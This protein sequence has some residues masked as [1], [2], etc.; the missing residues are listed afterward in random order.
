MPQEYTEKAYMDFIEEYG[1]HFVD[2]MVMGSMFGQQSKFSSS[3]WTTMES[4]GLDISLA[5]RY[6]GFGATA[7][8]SFQTDDEKQKAQQFEQQSSGQSLYSIGA[9][10]PSDNSATTWMAQVVENPV[11]IS[12]QLIQID[13]LLDDIRYGKVISAKLGSDDKTKTLQAN[14]Q[15]AFTVYCS[16]LQQLGVVSSCDE[17]GPAPPFPSLPALKV[18]E[19]TSYSQSYADHGTGSHMDLSMWKPNLDDGQFYVGDACMPN[20]NK[21]VF[22]S[23]ALE[24][25]SDKSALADPISMDFVWNDRSTGGDIDGGYF[26]PHCPDGYVPLGSVGEQFFKDD[27]TN[28]PPSYWPKLKCVK[29]AYTE[30]V[31]FSSLNWADHGSGGEHDGSIF[32]GIEGEY[33]GK[34]LVGPC[35]GASGYPGSTPGYKLKLPQQAQSNT[36]LHGNAA[37]I[38]V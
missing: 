4:S 13:T 29:E 18:V 12:F 5:A 15:K 37:I 19:V 38:I 32:N 31:T 11:P 26:T 2:S 25:G 3:A 36:R 30:P 1:T 17:P 28:P 35:Q 6:S 9:A 8:G 10:P 22:S 20:Y 23:I 21:P 33:S 24:L 27:D 34:Q 14:L 16:H 7:S